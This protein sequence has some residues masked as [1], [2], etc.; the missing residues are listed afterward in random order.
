MALPWWSIRTES[1]WVPS[2]METSDVFLLSQR[3]DDEP[4][5]EVM[6]DRPV[7][8]FLDTGRDDL[9]S[10]I[11]SLRIRNIPIV[12]SD[13]CPIRVINFNELIK[14]D[15]DKTIAVIMA[16]GEGTRLRPLTENIPKPMIAV[17]GRPVLEQILERLK[18]AGIDKIFISVNYLS[19]MIE[20]YFGDGSRFGVRIT[21]L[22]EDKKLGTAGSLALLRPY[23]GTCR[24]PILVINGDVVTDV[25]FD[26]FVAFHRQHRSVLSLAAIDYHLRI[27]FGVLDISGHHVIG[28]EEKPSRRF[29]CNAGIYAIESDIV[30]RVPQDTFYDMTDLLKDVIQQGLPVSA[31]PVHEHWIDIGSKEDLMRAKQGFTDIQLEKG[32]K[33]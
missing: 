18:L 21:Y 1:S 6:H 19:E 12:D 26:R 8:A 3:S 7:K 4:C 17:C 11:T 10:L 13:G 16:G 23:I 31:F 25:H 27:P 29:L 9:V 33:T 24:H 15:D 20:E 2:R 5:S 30:Y 32:M 14:E 28:L 22:R